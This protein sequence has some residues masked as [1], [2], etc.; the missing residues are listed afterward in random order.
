M[1][2]LAESFLADLADLSDE[3]AE[4]DEGEEGDEQEDLMEEDKVRKRLRVIVGA[5]H[6]VCALH[7]AVIALGSLPAAG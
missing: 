6:Q 7:S 2:T 3:E 4:Q 5:T 1:A